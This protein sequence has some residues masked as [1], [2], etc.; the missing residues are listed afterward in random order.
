MGAE[1]HASQLWFYADRGSHQSA[2]ALKQPRRNPT[3]RVTV[4]LYLGTPWTH[5]LDAVSVRSAVGL[6][7]PLGMAL[8]PAVSAVLS[9]P[10]T[11]RERTGE[12]L[13]WRVISSRWS[14][15]CR[16]RFRSGFPFSSSS[17][18]TFGFCG[19]GCA[20][21]NSFNISASLCWSL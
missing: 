4:R 15:E 12:K 20:R 11:P 16:L 17:S 19:C 13:P 10:T 9:R 3:Q 21:L 1:S 2:L 5:S 8:L 18:S 14:P 7:P 6:L